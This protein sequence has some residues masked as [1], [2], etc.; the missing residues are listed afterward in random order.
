MS[1]IYETVIGL[2]VHIELKTRTK[3]FCA[4]PTD[5]GADP[6]TQ[7]CPICAGMPGTL[8]VLNEKVVEYAVKAGLA[9]NCEIARHSKFDRKNYFYPDLPKAYQISQYDMPICER[10]YITVTT[11]EGEKRVGITRIHIEED[12][13]KLVHDDRHGTLIDLNRSGI[14]LIEV[15]SEPDMR[16]SSEAVAYLK[17]L[18]SIVLYTGI[19]DAK[20]NEGSMRCDVNISVREEGEIKLGTRVEIKNLNSFVNVQKAVEHE[21]RRQVLAIEAGEGVT[22]ET[23]RFDPSTGKTFPMRTKEDAD[24]YR[25]FPDPDLLPVVLDD[26]A[27]NRISVSIPPLPDERKRIYM[28][29]FGLS[30]YHSEQLV[31]DRAVSDFFDAAASLT[32]HRQILASLVLSEILRL[33]GDDG[34]IAVSPAHIAAIAD[35]LS[36]SRINGSGARKL[37]SALWR[38]DNDP[39]Y[40]VISLDLEQMNDRSILENVAKETISQNPA[41]VRDFKNGK[42]SALKALMGRAMSATG[43][44]A[45][46]EIL[47]ELIMLGF[48]GQ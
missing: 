4:C 7:C 9:T 28:E 21:F 19:S 46:P 39:E 35:M 40:L 36:C 5:F 29:K 2:E 22:Q 41:M 12:A 38:T 11:G 10:G 42:Q 14:P 31:L 15:V 23:R 25:Y 27:I 37:L 45:N 3:I 8:P 13:A 34:N 1:G 44:R 18:R 20:M 48:E 30:A 17:K 43:G 24:D 47:R 26:A 6:N 32:Q 16:S 33:S